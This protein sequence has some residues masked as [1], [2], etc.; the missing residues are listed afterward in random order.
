M[1]KIFVHRLQTTKSTKILPLENYP[2]Y[3]TLCS[4]LV[5]YYQFDFEVET[6]KVFAIPHNMGHTLFTAGVLTCVYSSVSCT[7][8]CMCKLKF[9]L[10]N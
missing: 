4:F 9:V 5:I 6:P 1:G 3:G 10:I 8:I 7:C 2:L